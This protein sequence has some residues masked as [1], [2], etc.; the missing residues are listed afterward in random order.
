MSEMRIKSSKRGGKQNNEF[1]GKNILER[2]IQYS[3]LSSTDI[4]LLL[5]FHVFI[6][7]ELGLSIAPMSFDVLSA[8]D[9][10]GI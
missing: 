3:A 8:T 7:R 10:K 5:I 2:N 4:S 9:F 1:R 6:H